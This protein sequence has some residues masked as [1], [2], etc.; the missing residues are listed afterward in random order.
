MGFKGLFLFLITT[1]SISNAYG[2]ELRWTAET[3]GLGEAKQKPDLQSILNQIN[4][5]TQTD[6]ALAANSPRQWK[7]SDFILS[8]NRPLAFSQFYHWQQV[9]DGITVDKKGVRLWTT[10]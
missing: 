8:E 1:I 5:R 4:L 3:E 9:N 6:R 2:L 7:T 10:P